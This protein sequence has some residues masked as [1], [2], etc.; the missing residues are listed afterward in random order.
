MLAKIADVVETAGLQIQAGRADLRQGGLAENVGSDVFDRAICDFV[1][2]ADIFVLTRRDPGDDLSPGD[3]R[4]EWPRDRA[5]RSRSS[6]R[7]I[8]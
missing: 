3:F 6:R 4:V 2:E 5:G 7:N 1:D 8:A